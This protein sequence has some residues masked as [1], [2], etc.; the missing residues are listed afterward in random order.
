MQLVEFCVG[1]ALVVAVLWDV[2]E[3][4]VVPRPARGPVRLA[5]HLVR[6]TWRLW[7]ATGL[8][9]N[10]PE[11]RER[12]LGSYAPLAVVLLLLCWVAGLILG[13]GLELHALRSQIRPEPTD[14]STA[15]YFAGT[16]LLTLGFGD[17]VA[18]GGVARAAVLAAAVSGLG[19]VALVITFLFSLYGSFQ[20]REMLVVT[21]DAR[22][23]APPSGVT[24]LETYVRG[25]MLDDL[26]R[27]FAAWEL[28]AAEVLDSHLAYPIL[29]YFRSTH[30]NESWVSALGA[31]LD[32]ATLVLTT[33][34]AGPRGPAS[35]MHS[36]GRH[37]VQ[38]V[39]NY[40]GLTTERQV[41]VE[42]AEFEAARTRLAAAGYCLRDLED[43]WSSF[44]QLRS[45]YAGP[46]NALAKYWATPPA[47]WIGDR[48]VLDQPARHRVHA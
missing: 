17:V 6:W 42:R 7:R 5:R 37:L 47:Q 11:R 39:S 32:A 40:F 23:G 2:F 33:V 38:D 27:T 44:G 12:L 48:S 31:L 28:W 41:G 1:L 13:Y 22:A 4:V 30:D 29:A 25:A 18:T 3:S 8:R 19:V 34:D 26:P 45:A 10:S 20:R 24:L 21:L 14:L 46:L 9:L 16:S 15:L 35:M 36:V 43:S